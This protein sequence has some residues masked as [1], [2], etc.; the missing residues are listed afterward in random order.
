[1]HTEDLG[2][3]LLMVI[4]FQLIHITSIIKNKNK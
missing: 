2:I 4:W 3:I 1:M